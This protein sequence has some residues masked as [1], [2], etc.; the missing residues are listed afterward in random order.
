MRQEERFGVLELHAQAQ[1]GGEKLQILFPGDRE[2]AVS[3][4]MEQV[5]IRAVAVYRHPITLLERN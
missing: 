3:K 4:A 2:N 1:H 5:V